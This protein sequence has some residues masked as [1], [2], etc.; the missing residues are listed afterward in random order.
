MYRKII[1]YSR[2]CL[3]QTIEFPILSAWNTR[4]TFPSFLSRYKITIPL[5]IRM[6]RWGN[7]PRMASDGLWSW[8]GLWITVGSNL[9]NCI[10]NRMHPETLRK[11]IRQAEI[12]QG[13]KDRSQQVELATLDWI[14][15]ITI[16]ESWDR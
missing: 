6:S 11:W 1:A 2:L 15:G 8:K 10:K 5:R 12:A 16:K 13:R 9:L 3:L 7:E 14:I 4:H